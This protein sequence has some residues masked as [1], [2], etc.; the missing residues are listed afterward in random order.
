MTWNDKPLL[1]YIGARLPL[2]AG[3]ALLMFAAAAQQQGQAAQQ[4]SAVA[5]VAGNGR[6]AG[7]HHGPNAG[8]DGRV[9]LMAKAL[10]LDTR[11]QVELR[12]ILLQQRAS[13]SRVWGDDSMPAALRVAATSA[14]GDETADRIRALLTDAQKK[15]YSLPKP[16]HQSSADPS[17]RSLEEWMHSSSPGDYPQLPS[18]ATAAE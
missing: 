6:H 1:C 2:A 5:D 17:S 13:V 18:G 12:K 14:I 9:Q 16:E 4:T 7:A 11:Q 3:V 15:Q 8:V 10:D